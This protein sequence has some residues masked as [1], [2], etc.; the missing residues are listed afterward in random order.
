MKSKKAIQ[1]VNT[2]MLGK[3]LVLVLNKS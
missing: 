3:K 1:K 2:Q